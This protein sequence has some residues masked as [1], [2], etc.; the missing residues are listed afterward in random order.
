MKKM[1][2]FWGAAIVAAVLCLTMQSCA[3]SRN[4]YGCPERI[5]T[6]PSILSFLK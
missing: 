2:K 5:E 1:N 4:K 6:S 3:S